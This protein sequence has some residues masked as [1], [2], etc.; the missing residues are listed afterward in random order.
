MSAVFSDPAALGA[1]DPESRR[2]VEHAHRDG[3]RLGLHLDPEARAKVEALQTRISKL[4]ACRTLVAPVRGAPR[5]SPWWAV[6][7]VVLG[8]GIGG[9]HGVCLGLCVCVF[10]CLCVLGVDWGVWGGVCVGWGVCGVEGGGGS[11]TL[12]L[13]SCTTASSQKDTND[14]AACAAPCDTMPGIDFQ[15]TLGEINTKLGFTKEELAGNGC[16]FHWARYS[17]GFVG[18][19]LS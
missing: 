8:W 18:S 16:Q 17:V 6:V 12:A 19:L 2:F 5:V 13:F 3:R 11:C 4:C 10:V 14:N 7:I 1:L 15:H 9:L